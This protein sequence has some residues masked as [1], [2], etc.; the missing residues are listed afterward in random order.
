MQF[1]K[2]SHQNEMCK[3]QF[4][5]S[6]RE[7]FINNSF[8]IITNDS[9]DIL[10]I[11]FNSSILGIA[12]WGKEGFIQSQ[13]WE[14]DADLDKNTF[15]TKN[16]PAFFQ[17]AKDDETFAIEI[18]DDCLKTFKNKYLHDL[19]KEFCV[20]KNPQHFDLTNFKIGEEL[21]IEVNEDDDIISIDELDES[22]ST[23][24]KIEESEGSGD[25]E[26]KT[27]D[28]LDE[29]QFNQRT[30][31]S[32]VLIFEKSKNPNRGVFKPDRWQNFSIPNHA[33]LF[34]RF[35]FNKT[36]INPDSI[37]KED[38][39]RPP[40]EYNIKLLGEIIECE[41]KYSS[42]DLDSRDVLTILLTVLRK[43]FKNEGILRSSNATSSDI[44]RGLQDS[45]KYKSEINVLL[46]LV[47]LTKYANHIPSDNEIKDAILVCKS[48]ISA[49]DSAT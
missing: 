10:K 11:E 22:Q 7:D 49:S 9:Q 26:T 17:G 15:L 48:I 34:R 46:K 32:N 47:D 8:V 23:K 12:S 27:S 44:L 6:L 45:Y 40:S 28:E 18:L 42:N 2:K 4:E 21:E 30:I 43:F 13:T 5:H 35:H 33:S 16:Y 3:Y 20:K 29:S 38:S 19:I 36:E 37:H 31:I 24:E 41:Q 1:V 14:S 25:A 39:L